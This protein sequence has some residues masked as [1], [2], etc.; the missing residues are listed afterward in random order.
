MNVG[1]HSVHIYCVRLTVKCRTASMLSLRKAYW[2]LL[3]KCAYIGACI[4][5][6]AVYTCRMTATVNHAGCL[7]KG[8]VRG[9]LRSATLKESEIEKIEKKQVS[10]P[11]V[12]K[13]RGC[14]LLACWI[15]RWTV[16]CISW[17]YCIMC[18]DTVWTYI[19]VYNCIML[20]HVVTVS[21]VVQLCRSTPEWLCGL[22]KEAIKH[23]MH[24]HVNCTCILSK[25]T[26]SSSSNVTMK[27]SCS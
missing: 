14:S 4:A 1:I 27:G 24:A 23:Y 18:V 21:F 20:N 13:A 17:V 26:S 3:I 11:F 15:K 10:G 2:P 8:G 25:W 16:L 19:C 9:W 5:V 7:W 6:F 22:R 12:W